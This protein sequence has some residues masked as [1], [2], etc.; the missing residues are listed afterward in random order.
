MTNACYMSTVLIIYFT[1]VP[2][3]C[4]ILGAYVFAKQKSKQ[5]L[6]E[7]KAKNN[8][9]EIVSSAS[10]SLPSLAEAFADVKYLADL[11]IAKEL[12][13]KKHPA[14]K[15]ADELRAIAK[16]KKALLKQLKML[17]YQG[18][19]LENQ[20]P[21]LTDY[22][23]LSVKDA[24]RYA[25]DVDTDYDAIR[26]WLSPEEYSKL[27][28]AKKN[29]LA[30]DRWRMRVKTPWEAGIDYE[31]FVGY[32]YE[33]KG[34]QVD[35]EGALKGKEDRGVDI[36]AK[37]G[38]AV[39]AIQCKRYSVLKSKYVHE[40]TVAQIYGVAKVIAMENPGKIVTPI[41]YTSSA[42]ADEAK[43]FADYL[44]VIVNENVPLLDDYPI[45]KCNVGKNGEKIYHLP[46]DQQYDKVKIA[47][48]P[49]ALYVRTVAEAE[50]MGFRRAYR[51]KGN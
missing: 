24:A 47:G 21:W 7:K 25:N 49:N 20:L 13:T 14:Y 35:Y 45:I 16:E 23:S 38:N 41:I 4:L 30:L 12:E 48:K 46:F 39:L 43:K 51:W 36:I 11:D 2:A 27:T 34:F 5:I 29:Q 22:K 31:R 10:Q 6:I 17:Q 40:N 37:S 8:V 32:I 19:F 44:G 1:A 42:L 9:D 50:K 18:Q 33:S 28:P 26:N 15:A 3:F